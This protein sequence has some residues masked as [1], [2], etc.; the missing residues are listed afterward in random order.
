M[1]RSIIALALAVDVASGGY[2][3][4]SCDFNNPDPFDCDHAVLTGSAAKNSGWVTLSSGTSVNGQL[5]FTIPTTGYESI[6]KITVSAQMYFGNE[7]QAD[8]FGV[9]AGAA[10]GQ[11]PCTDVSATGLGVC[12]DIYNDVAKAVRSGA[13]A[14]SGYSVGQQQ[15]DDDAFHTLNA[16]FDYT[17]GSVATFTWASNSFS[18]QSF[19]FTP[20]ISQ[21][22]VVNFMSWS[23]AIFGNFAMQSFNIGV[24][25]TNISPSPPPPS[26]SP[27]PP[28]SPPSPPPSP[29]P[30]PPPLYIIPD[31]TW[32]WFDDAPQHSSCG[33]GYACCR[34]NWPGNDLAFC[35]MCSD[36]HCSN[37]PLTN[38]NAAGTEQHAC[39]QQYYP[40]SPP[41]PPTPPPTVLL[42][43][44]VQD[45]HLRLPYGGRTDFRGEDKQWFAFLSAPNVSVN[46]FTEAASFTLNGGKLEVNGSFIT[47]AAVVA[48]MPGGT[49]FNALFNA[50]ATNDNLWS[51][52]LVQGTCEKKFSLGPHMAKTCG[53]VKAAVDMSSANFTIGD[54]IVTFKAN[55]VFNHISGATK[56]VD[57]SVRAIDAASAALNTHG[58]LGQAFGFKGPIAKAEEDV[59]PATGKV[60]TKAQAGGVIFG[61]HTEYVVASAFETDFRYSKFNAAR[62]VPVPTKMLLL[63]IAAEVDDSRY[64]D[65]APAAA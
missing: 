6:T 60:T 26:A 33:A 29:S 22:N 43:K 39:V 28:P 32:C 9:V 56:R 37:I 23:G 3:S 19:S 1:F 27:S 57:L 47:K 40:P 41:S 12:V 17:G 7:G 44:S 11:N 14:T 52:R 54:F 21:N 31:S 64:F 48:K 59:Y 18:G 36:I 65:A 34:S 15:A 4:Y 35:T 8:A 61:K 16:V 63:P 38:N 49:V 50:T 51:W 30:A 53:T 10:T 24:F 5:V 2:V 46:V 58:I 13:T 42:G 62:V 55:R 45:P 20:T 25:Y